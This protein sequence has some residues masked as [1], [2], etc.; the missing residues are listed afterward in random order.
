[1]DDLVI[2]IIFTF[3]LSRGLTDGQ[4]RYR[5]DGKPISSALHQTTER[6]VKKYAKNDKEKKETDLFLKSHL[7]Q[8]VTFAIVFIDL[9]SR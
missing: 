1:M 4:I 3:V 5:P 6:K 7:S 2:Y 8:S 9:V